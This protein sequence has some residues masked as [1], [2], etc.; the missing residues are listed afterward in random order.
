MY[1]S[2]L[3][4]VREHAGNAIIHNPAIPNQQNEAA[5][6]TTASSIFDSLQS[7]MGN[8]GVSSIAGMFINGNNSFGN[9]VHQVAN[10]A[11]PQLVSQLGIAPQTAA[12]VSGNLIPQVMSSLVNRANDVNDSSFNVQDI[13]SSLIGGGN[14]GFSLDSLLNQW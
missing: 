13:I 5:I 12:Q 1:E 2:L 3:S 7:I 4:L 8:G 9:I 6:A 14:E 10:E 11:V